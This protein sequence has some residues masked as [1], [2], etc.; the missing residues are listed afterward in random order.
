MA[1][2]EKEWGTMHMAD[3]FLRHLGRLGMENSLRYVAT[4]LIG[5][6]GSSVELTYSLTTHD[7]LSLLMGSFVSFNRGLE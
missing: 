6:L 7:F 1:C 4:L 5:L 3:A 2:R